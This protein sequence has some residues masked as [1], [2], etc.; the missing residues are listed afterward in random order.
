MSTTTDTFSADIPGSHL[1]SPNLSRTS[2]SFYSFRVFRVFEC[3]ILCFQRYTGFRKESR[4]YTTWRSPPG[5]KSS[6]MKSLK[7]RDILK[8]R[9][10]RVNIASALCAPRTGLLGRVTLVHLHC[11][12]TASS[13]CNSST[14]WQIPGVVPLLRP[15]LQYQAHS[16]LFFLKPWMVC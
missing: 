13:Y 10:L 15:L 4:T 6:L 8:S 11:S 12:L 14:Y 1:Y 7:T 16:F 5:I 2:H 3:L 9:E